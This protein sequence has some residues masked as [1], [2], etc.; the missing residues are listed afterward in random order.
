MNWIFIPI[1]YQHIFTRVDKTSFAVFHTI[2]ELAFIFGLIFDI[3]LSTIAVFLVFFPLSQVFVSICPCIYPIARNVIKFE[4]TCVYLTTYVTDFAFTMSHAVLKLA[5]V[6]RAI[7]PVI[8][9]ETMPFI[10]SPFTLILLTII[11]I[12]F[13]LTTSLKIPNFTNVIPI[14]IANLLHSYLWCIIQIL[15]M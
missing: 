8:N 11:K 9:T 14:R 4:L 5:F 13:A 6:S 10:S 12:H 15:R 7:G 1:P 2:F 3:C